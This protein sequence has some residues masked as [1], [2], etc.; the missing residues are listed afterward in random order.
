MDIFTAEKFGSDNAE[1]E[2]QT[3]SLEHLNDIAEMTL[4]E[5]RQGNAIHEE[6]GDLEEVEPEF[7]GPDGESPFAAD[8]DGSDFFGGGLAED[9]GDDDLEIT[10]EKQLDHRWHNEEYVLMKEDV[11][12]EAI[13]SDPDQLFTIGNSKVGMDTIIFNL[14]PARFCPSLENGMCK[15]VKPIDGEYKIACYAYQD[16]RQYKTALQLRIRQMRFWDTH[17]ADDIFEKLATFYASSRGSSLVKKMWKAPD[18]I[19]GTKKKTPAVMG[20]NKDSIKLQF[21]RF[22]QSGDLKDVFDAKKMDKV[23]KLA[24]EKLNLV[25]Y[26]YTARKDIL[27]KYKFQYVHIQGSGFSAITGINKPTKTKKGVTIYGKSFKA[28]P[29]IYNKSHDLLERQPGVL[30]YEDIMEKKTPDGKDNPHFDRWT[31]KNTGGWFPCMGDCNPCRACK[32]DDVKL[33]ACKIHRSFQK[34][35]DDWQEVETTETG[36]K[37][38]QKSPVFQ[39]KGY[40][41]TWSPEMEAEY[42]TR[43]KLIQAEKDFNKLPLEQQIEVLNDNLH[44]LYASYDTDLDDETLDD[45]KRRISNKEKQTEKRGIDWKEIKREY[46]NIPQKGRK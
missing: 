6:E 40:K 13:E 1:C 17:S 18:K 11:D 21:I 8:D 34:I 41:K 5:Q 3:I 26:T 44:E 31:P 38:H 33:I 39:G 19:S 36:Y 42:E 43:A 20:K 25:T 46:K 28:Y 7:S 24:L 45:L 29:S 16:E 23:A 32:S 9:D 27:A 12:W 35:S 22:N 30:Y 37:V 2:Q 4:E 15:I 10:Y 14:Q